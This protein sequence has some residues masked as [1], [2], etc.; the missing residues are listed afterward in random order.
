LIQIILFSISQLKIKKMKQ[1]QEYILDQNQLVINQQDPGNQK[2]GGT[3]YSPDKTD[4][5][6]EMEETEDYEMDSYTTEKL[7]DDEP[8]EEGDD[9]LKDVNE[10]EKYD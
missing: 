10:D 1:K 3:N 2:N 8:V 4:E 6:D 5:Y 9:E 7:S